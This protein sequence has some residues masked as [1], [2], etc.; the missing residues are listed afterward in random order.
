MR[1][2]AMFDTPG[3]RYEDGA[4]PDSLRQFIEYHNALSRQLIR[5][6]EMEKPEFWESMLELC[7]QAVTITAKA[8]TF[9]NGRDMSQVG[10]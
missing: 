3:G 10:M 7:Q 2:R 4:N 5:A 9:V 8:K 1:K 6:F